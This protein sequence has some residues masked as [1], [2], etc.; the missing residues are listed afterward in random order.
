VVLQGLTVREAELHIEKLFREGGYFV[1]PQV[2]ISVSEYSDRAVAILGQVGNPDKVALQ[3]EVNSI[4][5]LEAIT[6]AGGFTRIAK[7]DAVQVTRTGKDGLRETM[8]V[9]VQE[10]LRSRRPGEQREFQLIAG[11]VV[12]V[13][14]R[15]F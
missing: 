13:P 15:A 3:P 2:I 8:I 1:D 4:G 14:E 10:L 11:D 5:I 12:F 6:L 9:N 7:T